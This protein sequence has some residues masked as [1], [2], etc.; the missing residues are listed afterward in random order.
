MGYDLLADLV[1]GLHLAFVSFVGGG[2]FVVAKWPQAAWVHIPA[3]LWGALLEFEGWLC[4]LTP[5][6]HWL[7]RK[8]GGA[9]Y[10]GDFLHQYLLTL[11]YPDGLTAQMQW[12][13]GA[14]VLLINAAIY[15]WLWRARVGRHAGAAAG[16]GRS[17][18]P[19]PNRSSR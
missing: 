7:R 8:A 3:V 11:L 13:L 19:P 14:T 16:H 10:E 12:A 15:V 1:V 18:V 5:V 6:E 17:H 4:P 2:G 9:G